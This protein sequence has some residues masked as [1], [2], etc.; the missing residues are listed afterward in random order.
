ME[1]YAQQKKKTVKMNVSV[2]SKITTVLTSLITDAYSTLVYTYLFLQE[3]IELLKKL[4]LVEGIEEWKIQQNL[5]DIEIHY[6]YK[7]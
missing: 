1:M 3:Q 7:Q 6:T 2:W 4:C 5:G